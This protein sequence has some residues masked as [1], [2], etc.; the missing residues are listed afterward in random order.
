MTFP[1]TRTNKKQSD[2][3][4][5]GGAD[6]E[7]CRKDRKAVTGIVAQE[8]ATGLCTQQQT[9]WSRYK[10]RKA[11]ALALRADERRDKLRK[12]S[13]RSKYPLIRR[14]LNGETCMEPSMYPYANP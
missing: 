6:S 10:E 5:L 14:Y 3:A 13:G 12:A 1:D 2:T 11:D 8:Q 4:T 9:K 7:N